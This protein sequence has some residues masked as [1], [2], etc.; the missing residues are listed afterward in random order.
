MKKIL[1]EWRRYLNEF[2][3]DDKYQ[4]IDAVVDTN[5]DAQSIIQAEIDKQMKFYSRTKYT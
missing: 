2:K 3:M 1:N 4:D 5:V